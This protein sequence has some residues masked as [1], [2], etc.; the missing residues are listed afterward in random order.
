MCKLNVT[1][2]IVYNAPIND[3]RNILRVLWLT[4]L[5]RCGTGLYLEQGVLGCREGLHSR[6]VDSQPEQCHIDIDIDT[7][8]VYSATCLHVT[9]LI[10]YV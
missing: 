3:E 10:A 8:I 4:V 7:D 2:R 9:Y 5:Y 6:L 1:I